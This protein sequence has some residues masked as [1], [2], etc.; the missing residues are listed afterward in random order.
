M[1]K[2]AILTTV[3]MLLGGCT[4]LIGPTRS[5][6]PLEPAPAR[7]EPPSSLVQT[8]VPPPVQPQA[9]RQP[10]ATPPQAAITIDNT[11][12]DAFRASWGRLRSSLSPAQQTDLNDAVVR[13]AFAPYGGATNVPANLRNS[14]VVPEMIR[15]QIAGLTYAEIIALAP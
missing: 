12:I 5:E 7:A 1:R 6:A 4:G 8:P 9:P 14:P 11:S 15:H 13:L 10:R 3:T 2:S